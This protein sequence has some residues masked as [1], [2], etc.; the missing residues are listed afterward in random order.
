[1]TK[2]RYHKLKQKEAAPREEVTRVVM[3]VAPSCKEA[4]KEAAA[5]CGLTMTAFILGCLE[6]MEVFG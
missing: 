1:M 5:E 4:I 6:E 3:E 2:R